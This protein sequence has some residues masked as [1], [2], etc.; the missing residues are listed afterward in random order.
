MDSAERTCA[1]PERDPGEADAGGG[2]EKVGLVSA[3]KKAEGRRQ[4]SRPTGF[5]FC[6]CLLPF[7]PPSDSMG[8]GA[9]GPGPPGRR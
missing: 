6:F 8:G 9:D 7:E 3:R 4:K 1:R 5:A 2:E